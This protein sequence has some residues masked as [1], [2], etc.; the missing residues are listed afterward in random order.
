V[1]SILST[2][3][4]GTHLNGVLPHASLCVIRYKSNQGHEEE[5]VTPLF[6]EEE[7]RKKNM[8]RGEEGKKEEEKRGRESGGRSLHQGEAGAS[9]LPWPAT[10]L[11]RSLQAALAGASRAPLAGTSPWRR[12]LRAGG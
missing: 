12:R 9:R 8:R 10:M 4:L 11:G 5:E 3:D 1:N 6:K 7:E 2:L